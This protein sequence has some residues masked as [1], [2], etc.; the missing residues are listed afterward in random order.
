MRIDEV[1]SSSLVF[2]R[3]EYLRFSNGLLVPTSQCFDIKRL[4]VD[5]NSQVLSYFLGSG[6]DHHEN[7]NQ[8][9]SLGCVT[10]PVIASQ[11]RSKSTRTSLTSSRVSQLSLS[12]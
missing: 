8:P 7:H 12:R 2:K 6:V 10:L 9:I 11:S 5:F 1:K 4:A 3:A